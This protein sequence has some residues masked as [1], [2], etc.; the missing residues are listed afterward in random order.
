MTNCRR[1]GLTRYGPSGSVRPAKNPMTNEPVTF[2]NKC[3]ERKDFAKSLRHQSRSPEARPG[4]QCAAEHDPEICEHKKT[5]TVASISEAAAG[6]ISS[7]G[8]SRLTA[9]KAN[10]IAGWHHSR[11]TVAGKAAADVWFC[12]LSVLVTPLTAERAV[13]KIGND[14]TFDS[15]PSFSPTRAPPDERDRGPGSYLDAARPRDF[16]RGSFLSCHDLR[17][18]EQKGP[19]FWRLRREQLLERHLDF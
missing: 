1:R 2:T 5:P 8:S 14:L 13:R 16:S 7:G 4:S 10:S 17:C 19:A 18:G 9:G 12:R 11:L 3:A 6:V 15:V